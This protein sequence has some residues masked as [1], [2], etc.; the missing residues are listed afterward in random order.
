MLVLGRSALP[1][2]MVATLAA[3]AGAQQKACEIDEGQP[4]QVARAMLDLQLVQTAG[5]PEDA[6]KS[7]RDAIKLLSEGDQTKNAVGRALVKGK[8]LVTWMSQPGMTG[9]YAPRAA[10]G[11]T[12]EPTTQYDIVAGID[13]AFSV[14]EASNP[15]CTS[16]TGPWRQ[17]KGWVDLVNQAIEMGNAEG[18]SDTAATLAKRS[19]QLYRGA[20]Y[21]Y[22][23]LAKAAAEKQVNNSAIQ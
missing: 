9:G 23:V 15:E 3:T 4:N 1:A 11:F 22:M 6:A 20:P 16:Q 2:L 7:L 17:Q 10:L 5:K 21:G 14:V 13:S 8:A 12:T 19:L 18:K